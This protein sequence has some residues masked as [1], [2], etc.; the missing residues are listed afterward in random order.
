M[1]TIVQLDRVQLELQQLINPNI[2]SF[3]RG[4]FYLIDL[5]SFFLVTCFWFNPY[6]SE[7]INFSFLL[8]FLKIKGGNRKIVDF[9]LLEQFGFGSGLSLGFGDDSKSR[10]D[11]DG[12][13]LGGATYEL[14]LFKF[15]ELLFACKHI[16]FVFLPSSS[17]LRVVF[18]W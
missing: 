17:E 16:G 7:Q 4:Y 2:S 13:F 8:T 11:G 10:V 18:L 3:F 12:L 6:W 5:T 15:H 9:F 1:Q 14:F